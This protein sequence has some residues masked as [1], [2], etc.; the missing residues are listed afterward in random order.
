MQ[1]DADIIA[2]EGGIMPLENV[3]V[4]V[5]CKHTRD[6]ELIPIKMR[7]QDE[8]G[9]YQ[10]YTIKAYRTIAGSQNE[11]VLP[12]GVLVTSMLKS[13]EC[14][15]SVFGTEKRIWLYYRYADSVW[16]LKMF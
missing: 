7:V 1:R 8:E 2:E 6:G 11:A 14:K 4:D 15:I 5:I 12:N 10:T 13:F 16:M 9:E 3:P